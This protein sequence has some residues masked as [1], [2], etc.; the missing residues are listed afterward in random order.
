MKSTYDHHANICYLDDSNSNYYHDGSSAILT[1]TEGD[2]MVYFP[3]FWYKCETS[4]DSHKIHISTSQINGYYHSPT[5]LV[6]AYKAYNEGTSTLRSLSGLYRTTA[7]T[8]GQFYKYARVRGK[9]FHLIDYM[10]HRTIAWMF[11]TRYKNTDSQSICGTGDSSSTNILNGTT[12]GLGITDTTPNDSG[13]LVNFLGI[14]GCWGYIYEF[15]EGIHSNSSNNAVIAYDKPDLV[16]DSLNNYE[17][18]NGYSY[19]Q[20]N[21]TLPT[22]RKLNTSYLSGYIKDIWGGDYGDMTIAENDN[23]SS[24]PK[25][26]QYYCDYGYVYPSNT[27]IFARSHGSAYSYGG[28]SFLDGGWHSNGDSSDVGS[29]L[30]FDGTIVETSVADFKAISDWR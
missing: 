21:F 16:N 30:A 3:E 1:G 5:S 28:V 10:Q 18:D 11:Y 2:V 6:G 22:L 14:E 17:Y 19:L 26:H 20:S 4:T 25:E 8:I 13:R 9:G 29:R 12:N 24:S 23:S 27:H 7:L 15:I